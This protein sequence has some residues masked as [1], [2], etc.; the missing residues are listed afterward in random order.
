M[1]STLEGS[2]GITEPFSA[3]S[4]FEFGGKEGS[5]A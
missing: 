1:E 4:P 5:G 2:S 3:G